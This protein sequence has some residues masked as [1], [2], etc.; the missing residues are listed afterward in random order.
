MQQATVYA[1]TATRRSRAD[2]LPGRLR[3][4]RSVGAG[5]ANARSEVAAIQ[6]ALNGIPGSL[7]GPEP[8]LA[9]DGL[10]GPKTLAAI[11]GFQ[12][13]WL[14]VRD[15]RI[16]PGGPTLACLNA[17]VGAPSARAPGDLPARATGPAAR[18]W[19]ALGS[20]V[21]GATGFAA[22]R[23][24]PGALP[25]APRRDPLILD[26]IRAMVRLD[27]LRDNVLF[28]VEMA[29][30]AAVRMAERAF[31]YA[32]LLVT[33]SR[34]LPGWNDRE[35]ANRLAFLLLA[36][37][38]H[39]SEA[40]PSRA[41]AA[42]TR[43]LEVARRIHLRTISRRGAFGVLHDQSDRYISNFRLRPG[44]IGAAYN[45]G[46]GGAD[47]P[48]PLHHNGDRSDHIYLTPLWD[49]GDSTW[50]QCTLI[51]ELAHFVGGISPGIDDHAYAFQAHYPTLVP[52]L[53]LRN[54]DCYALYLAERY[55]GTVAAARGRDIDPRK[56]G[57]FPFVEAGGNVVLP[58]PP[59]GPDPFAFPCGFP[60]KR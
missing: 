35:A 11:R 22:L 36:K 26:I 47:R 42:A 32:N 50:K 20:A 56:M 30:K 9:T 58:E 19:G 46:L 55:H 45:I 15:G 23:A 28:G 43:V 8:P 31:D 48:N 14:D 40:E 6:S 29:M 24:A 10:I 33:P 51:H 52:S 57:N 53:R 5:G 25:G 17:A 21:I 60:R 59:S 12:A 18:A 16:D 41:L 34:G 7:A 44:D 4:A 13:G 1:V 2:L 49:R 39:L 54:T 38:F 37:H 3:L 27:D